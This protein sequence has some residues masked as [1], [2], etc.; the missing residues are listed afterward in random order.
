M[1]FSPEKGIVDFYTVAIVLANAGIISKYAVV[2]LLSVVICFRV[3][4]ILV[5]ITAGAIQCNST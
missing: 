3:T 4:H 5:H 1:N 2:S